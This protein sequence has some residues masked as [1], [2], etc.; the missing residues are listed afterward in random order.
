LQQNTIVKEEDDVDVLSE[1]CIDMKFE[2]VFIPSAFP[3]EKVEPEVSPLC[4]CFC[5]CFSSMS[6]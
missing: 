6:L 3:I 5:A 2:E 4:R 1:E